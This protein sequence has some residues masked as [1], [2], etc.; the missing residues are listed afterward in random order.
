MIMKKEYFKPEILEVNVIANNMLANS[1]G[2]ND[3][4]TGPKDTNTNRGDW[5]NVWGN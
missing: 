2:F 3:K 5:G 4:P 1:A